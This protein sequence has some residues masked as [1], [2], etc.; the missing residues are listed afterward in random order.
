M[1]I[2]LGGDLKHTQGDFS[3]SIYYDPKRNKE[4]LFDD[5]NFILRY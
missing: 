5:E 4:G 1:H 3:R 2:Y